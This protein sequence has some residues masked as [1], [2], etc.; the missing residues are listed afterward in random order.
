M[1]SDQF[2]QIPEEILK[3]KILPYFRDKE[4]FSEPIDY[5]ISLIAQDIRGNWRDGCD[6]RIDAIIELLEKKDD[7]E[8]K[9]LIEELNDLRKYIN[10]DGRCITDFSF[11][12]FENYKYNIYDN[13]DLDLY[14]KYCTDFLTY[15]SDDD[16]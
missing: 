15:E 11:Y 4:Y 13:F 5:M 9:E 3:D 12:D 1:N 2:K 8:S 16:Y 10:R 14:N 6:D 7:E